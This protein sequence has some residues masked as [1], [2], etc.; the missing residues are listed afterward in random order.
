MSSPGHGL[1]GRVMA[2]LL[3]LFATTYAGCGGSGSAEDSTQTVTSAKTATS[4]GTRG[5]TQSARSAHGAAKSGGGSTHSSTHDAMPS[6]GGRPLRRFTGDGN[7]RLGTI[8]VRS[9]SLLVWSARQ[10]ATRQP[11]IQIFT[12]NGFLLV[13]SKAPN[14]FIRLAGGTYRGVRVASPASWSIELRS[15]SS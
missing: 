15:L 5:E 8:A 14:G 1:A 6:P 9:P 4:S 3:V 12:S 2:I 7:A 10:P 11:A 13:N